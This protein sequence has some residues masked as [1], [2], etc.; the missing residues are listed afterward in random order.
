MYPSFVFSYTDKTKVLSFKFR[1]AGIGKNK[2]QKEVVY[3]KTKKGQSV[4]CQSRRGNSGDR[5]GG[6][7]HHP[8]LGIVAVG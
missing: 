3:E 4:Q 7:N 1:P 5:H 6:A 8:C 2:I